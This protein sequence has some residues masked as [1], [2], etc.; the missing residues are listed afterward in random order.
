VDVV[1]DLDADLLIYPAADK[2]L[3]KNNTSVEKV[4]LALMH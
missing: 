3:P 1:N 4:I 2:T